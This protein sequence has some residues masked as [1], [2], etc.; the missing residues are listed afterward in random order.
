M[1]PL[2]FFSNACPF[3]LFGPTSLIY[4]LRR[5]DC[6]RPLIYGLF[7]AIPQFFGFLRSL[8]PLLLSLPQSQA[9]KSVHPPCFRSRPIREPSKCFPAHSL[10]LDCSSSDSVPSAFAGKSTTTKPFSQLPSSPAL[11]T[12]PGRY[13]EESWRRWKFP[14]ITLSM[15]D[16]AASRAS[17]QKPMPSGQSGKRTHRLSA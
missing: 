4:H 9:D 3:A 13:C 6:L 17:H 14:K 15:R 2:G 16:S 8:V 11:N 10:I 5:R 7:R 12:N 1:H